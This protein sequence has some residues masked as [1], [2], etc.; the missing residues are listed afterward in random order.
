MLWLGILLFALVTNAVQIPLL[1]L[2]DEWNLNTPPNPNSTGHLIFDTVSSLLQ[3]WPNTSHT[4][5]PGTLTLPLG[6][7][8]SPIDP[9]FARLFCN[10]D[11]L[12]GP[13]WILT[14][15]TTRPLRVLYFD[16]SSATKMPDGPMDTQDL[17][18]W[19]AVL[20]KRATLSW[21]YRRLDRLCNMGDPLGFDAYVSEVMLCNFTDGV[22]ITSLSSL[23]EEPLFPHHGYSFIQSSKWHDHY[24]GETRVQLDLAHLVSLYD[25]SLA[26]SLVGG[27]VGQERR[28]HRVLGIDQRDTDAV[29][30][31]VRAMPSSPSGSGI[32]WRTQFQVI[33]D[34]YATRLELLQSTLNTTGDDF[35]MPYRLRS[36]VPPPAG[37]D[38]AWAGPVFRVCARAHTSSIESVT[39]T[40]TA[41]ERLLLASAQETTREICRTLIGMWAQGMLEL[42]ASATVPDSLALEWKSEIDRL[43][44]WL[45]WGVWIKC[46]PACA[47]DE[48]CYLPGAPFSMGEW[49]GSV[50]RCLRLV[51]PYTG[52]E[53]WLL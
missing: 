50:P 44:D 27:R 31:R 46:R 49:N 28:A 41:S 9:E 19:G 2:P 23:E 26:P 40:L 13:C 36:A 39:S 29:I 4:I 8:G 48:S 42:R 18:A 45:G 43:V 20:P 22:Q 33:R 32:D 10:H 38:T 15:V 30:A 51:E 3:H 47:S 7:N 11:D 21:E 24:P 6:A 14:L 37:W 25:M 5:V 52:L 35:L 34:R 12:G 1:N 53:D 17:L 16:G